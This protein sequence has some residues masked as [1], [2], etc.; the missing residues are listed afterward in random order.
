MLAP[1]IQPVADNSPAI[2]GKLIGLFQLLVQF[3]TTATLG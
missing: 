2:F 3:G 1:I